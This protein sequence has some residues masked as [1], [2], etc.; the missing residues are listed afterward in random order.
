MIAALNPV[1]LL[2][3]LTRTFTEKTYGNYVEIIV[4]SS[5][6]IPLLSFN[7][8]ELILQSKSSSKSTMIQKYNESIIFSFSIVVIA[9]IISFLTSAVSH[10]IAIVI[11][12]F[13]TVLQTNFRT[14][15]IGEN[16][17]RL[18]LGVIIFSELFPVVIIGLL[19]LFQPG[20]ISVTLVIYL[21]SFFRFILFLPH[22]WSLRRVMKFEFS[23]ESMKIS[24][25]F[26]APLVVFSIVSLLTTTG[27]K[28]IVINSFSSEELAKYSANF[29][30]GSL[31]VMV[32]GFVQ[33]S[34][35]NAIYEYKQLSI[36]V[37][38]ALFVKSS[39][40]LLVAV[41]ALSVLLPFGAKFILPLEYFDL[42]LVYITMA[43]GFFHSMYFLS[44]PLF[45][46]AER[47]WSLVSYVTFFTLVYLSVAYFYNNAQLLNIS[48]FYMC[49]WALISIV[50]GYKALVIWKR[51]IVGDHE[52]NR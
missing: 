19:Y 25:G 17:A 2:Y 26:L 8:S 31:V 33:V 28:W 32:G 50:L 34:W 3:I 47:N 24:L 36:N 52:E 10:Y 40:I 4:Y 39:A 15:L 48:L 21:L 44:K 23:M 35:S 51:L 41:V 22:I 29:Q 42:K 6:I 11:F 20:Y 45:L 7:F 12:T 16:K 38:R 27:D 9:L 1:L 43:G 13:T 37:L 5:T 30:I 14:F 46:L 49:N 18:L